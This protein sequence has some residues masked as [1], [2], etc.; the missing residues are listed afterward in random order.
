MGIRIIIMLIVLSTALLHSSAEC[1]PSPRTT[2]DSSK[3]AKEKG[4][5][6]SGKKSESLNEHQTIIDSAQLKADLAK[7]LV[8]K[9]V[10]DWVASLQLNDKPKRNTIDRGD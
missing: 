8:Q 1:Q 3:Q 10:E 2:T 4:S 9:K 7:K 5:E 6:K